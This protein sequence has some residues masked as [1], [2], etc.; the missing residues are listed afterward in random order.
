M[1][2][3][4]RLADLRQQ[5][6]P[7]CLGLD[8]HQQIV[9]NW[10]YRFDVSGVERVAR[11]TIAA[12]AD[13][14]AVYKPQSAFFERFGAAGIAVLERVLADVADAGAISL[15]DVKRGDIGSTMSA[16]AAAYLSPDAPLAADAITL[17][18][19]LGFESLR[20]ALQLALDSG[21]GVYVL[22]RTSNPQGTGLQLSE[23]PSGRTVAQT[24]VDAAAE[25]NQRAGTSYVGLVI[26]A[27]H[28]WLD[29]NLDA[30]DG[31]IL[32]PGIGA[33]GGSVDGLQTLFGKAM[34][35]VLASVSRG[36]L[37][38]GPHRQALRSAVESYRQ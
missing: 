36:V 21:R 37:T 7:L 31:S 12:T 16:Y 8:P 15:L 27:T 18:P 35:N 14:V 29:V 9:E 28:T 6:G 10:G 2:F 34:V 22:C 32:A 25:E 30:F 4:Q 1:N 38:A 26:G 24:I 33:Q 19:Y 5:R 3:R 17:N 11:E 13:L 20:P 23:S